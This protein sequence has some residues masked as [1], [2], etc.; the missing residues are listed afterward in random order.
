MIMTVGKKLD[1]L[2]SYCNG[3]RCSE[4]RVTD[5]CGTCSLGP[6]EEAVEELFDKVF[7]MDEIEKAD[8]SANQSA[9]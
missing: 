8:Q 3:R 1:A 4:C 6:I 5:E 2:E 7:R 9:N